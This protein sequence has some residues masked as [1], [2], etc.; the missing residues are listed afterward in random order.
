MGWIKYV[1]MLFG[2]KKVVE[3]A[4][5]QGQ[6]VKDVHAKSSIRS[7]EFISAVMVGLGAVLAQAGGLVPAPYGTIIGAVS[8]AMYAISRGLAKKDDPMG[9]V[10]PGVS[11]SELLVTVIQQIATVLA[12]TS[13][14]VPPETAS[15]LLLIS[16]GAYGLSRGLA[17]G[18]AQP[19]QE[20]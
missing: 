3:E 11:T 9:G 2:G 16:N 6:I 20:K 14:A 12:A 1:K 8:G 7:T 15:T 13:G 18:G 17:K 10:K 4:I 5:A 19:D